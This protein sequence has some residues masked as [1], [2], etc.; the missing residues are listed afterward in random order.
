[1]NV[2]EIVKGLTPPLVLQAV[3]RSRAPS[4]IPVSP[5]KPEFSGDFA[6]FEEA[7]EACIGYDTDISADVWAKQLA[8]A[9]DSPKREIHVL[10]QQVHSAV[11]FARDEMKASRLS[12]LDIGG[13]NGLYFLWLRSLMAAVQLDWTVLETAKVVN[14]CSRLLPEA[15]FSTEFPAGRLFDIALISGTLQYLPNADET[16][17]KSAASSR[18]IILTR[19][20]VHDGATDKFMVQTVPSKIYSGSHAIRIFSKPNLEQR[21]SEIGEIALTWAVDWDTPSLALFGARSVGYLI[22]VTP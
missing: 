10:F 12:V 5:A 14:A 4:T 11:C 19:L 15:L 16:L 9:V 17:A 22:R 13:G 3:R 6:N 8:A 2:R 7:A 1:L 18:W 20:P 21:I